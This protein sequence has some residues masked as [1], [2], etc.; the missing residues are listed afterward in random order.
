MSGV[1]TFLRGRHSA[2]PSC[3]VRSGLNSSRRPAA[4]L[5]IRQTLF[6]EKLRRRLY[7]RTVLRRSLAG[8][9]SNWIIDVKLTSWKVASA[10]VLIIALGY[11]LFVIP[12]TTAP[13]AP[14]NVSE[15]ADA[16]KTAPGEPAQQAADLL[17]RIDEARTRLRSTGKQFGA[18]IRTA[19]LAERVD[20]DQ[21]QQA[22]EMALGVIRSL[23]RDMVDGG[24]PTFES[25][26]DLA[27]AYVGYLDWQE[28]T[29]QTDYAALVGDLQRSDSTPLERQ[30]VAKAVFAE[31]SA[32]EKKRDEKIQE[33]RQALSNQ[34]SAP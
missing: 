18:A 33:L 11:R 20:G 14:S 15:K 19:M 32:D 26:R 4:G 22:L 30:N 34:F 9:R 7:W 12:A 5:Q 10:A 24:E 3:W 31:R 8:W 2:Q 16:T 13:A 29:Y 1:E 21:L 25:G 23:R 28:E 6:P 27:K 17:K